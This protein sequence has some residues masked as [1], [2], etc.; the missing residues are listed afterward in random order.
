MRSPNDTTIITP[1]TAAIAPP[2]S[3]HVC[4]RWA[5]RACTVIGGLAQL[6]VLF[7]QVV[8]RGVDVAAEL[9]RTE[10]HRAQD[11]EDEEQVD[12]AADHVFAYRHRLLG[13]SILQLGPAVTRRVD[14]R[15]EPSGEEQD[16]GDDRKR[17]ARRV[18][19]AA[20][21]GPEAMRVG[22]GRVGDR[23]VSALGLRRGRRLRG[24]WV[25]GE[26]AAEVGCRAEPRRRAVRAAA[27]GGSTFTAAA[28]TTSADRSSGRPRRRS[29]GR[30]A[31][32]G[33]PR[34]AG[35]AGS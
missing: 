7:R 2:T 19:L 15:G 1:A 24:P 26:Q 20:A 18:P 32:S 4:L 33:A 12:D 3:S 31:R 5:F 34:S 28:A 13:D 25:H 21:T 22:R 10:P 30:A 16:P 17:A 35:A 11:R 27:T 29:R 14:D 8:R 23:F 6:R 9:V